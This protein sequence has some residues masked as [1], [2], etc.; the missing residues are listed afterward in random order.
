MKALASFMIMWS[1]RKTFNSKGDS[2]QAE[3]E[4]DKNNKKYYTI[5]IIIMHITHL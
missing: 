2:E 5:I 4:E 1:D 3:V